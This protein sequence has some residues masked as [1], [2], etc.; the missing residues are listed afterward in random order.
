MIVLGVHCGFSI[1]THEPGAALAINGK[2][3]ACCEEERYLRYKHA[4]GHIPV[5]AIAK[6]LEFNK[7]GI[8]DIKAVFISACKYPD[9]KKRV[10][11]YFKHY[12]GYS[13][14]VIMV[15]HQLSHLASAYFPSNFNKSMILSID[16]MGD[17]KSMAGGFGSNGKIKIVLTV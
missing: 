15:D 1:H 6:S 7:I 3:V 8:K 5:N 10:Q 4:R 17:F 14:E 2:I 9:L 16:G 11:V 13:P 12:F